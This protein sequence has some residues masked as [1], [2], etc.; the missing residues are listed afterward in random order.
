LLK[1][2]AVQ[3]LTHFVLFYLFIFH[4]FQTGSHPVAQ[5]DLKLST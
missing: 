5:V 4:G 2:G 1:F 3:R